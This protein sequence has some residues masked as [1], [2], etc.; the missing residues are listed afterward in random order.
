M[1]SGT[2][3]KTAA[4]TPLLTRPAP[5]RESPAW[6]RG[7]YAAFFLYLF[8]SSINVMGIG[9][10]TLPIQGILNAGGDPILA[11]MGGV[12]VTAI[13]QS[14][15]FTT[16]LI[17]TFV[18]AGK[19]N[20]DT[21]IFAVMG[22]NVGTSIT[23]N[24]VS[25]ATWRIRRQFRRAYTAAMMHGFVNLLTVAVLFPLE[26]ATGLLTKFSM[27]LAGLMGL[28]EIENPNSPVKMMTRPVVTLF[29]WFGDLVTT[30]D[31]AQGVVMALAGLMLL[32]GSLVML[33]TNLKGALLRRI[34]RLFSSFLFRS[35]L[36]ASV[37]GGIS[38]IM[39]QSSSV[40]TSLIVPLV[41]AGAIKLRRA[42]PF[43]L[44][45]NIGTTVTAVIVATANPVEA[46]VGVAICHVCFNVVAAAIWYP[47][48]FVPIGLATW[49]GQ[50]AA[51]SKWYYVAFLLVV[52]FA[53]PGL[54]YLISRL[55]G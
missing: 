14:S 10:K 13:V 42:F 54:G 2:S 52:Y 33:V 36:M 16:A 47:M 39:V 32:F 40:T 43:M 49:Y 48:R 38:T 3:R 25:L 22:A 11:L 29:E 21:A 19:M 28:K 34:E 9:L 53:I 20:L 24:L 37:V 46:A 18:A 55:L 31:R 17:I 26:L 41:G 6:L 4:T 44:G 30:T 15:S 35:D 7:L 45:C 5:A 51:R 8:L 50:L 1:A 27:Q 23:N 12:V